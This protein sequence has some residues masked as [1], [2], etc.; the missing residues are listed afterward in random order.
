LPTKKRIEGYVNR[1]LVRERTNKFKI[2]QNPHFIEYT[3]PLNKARKNI[4]SNQN[5]YTDQY[6]MKVNISLTLGNTLIKVENSL[7]LRIN[8]IQQGDSL[9][10]TRRPIQSNDSLL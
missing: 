4:N 1:E 7:L 3:S 5:E 9:D 2:Q 10:A 6:A 8:M